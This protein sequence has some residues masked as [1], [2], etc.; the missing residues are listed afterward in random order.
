MKRDIDSPLFRCVSSLD[1]DC[2]LPKPSNLSESSG[3]NALFSQIAAISPITKSLHT[4]FPALSTVESQLI[5][6]PSHVSEFLNLLEDVYP[7]EYFSDTQGDSF[8]NSFYKAVSDFSDDGKQISE[9]EISEFQNLNNEKNLI[10]SWNEFFDEFRSDN[11]SF[12]QV[13]KVKKL[14]ESSK[15]LKNFSKFFGFND[16]FSMLHDVLI[17]VFSKIDYSVNA[18]DE[19]AKSVGFLEKSEIHEN[20]EFEVTVII[21]NVMVC[22]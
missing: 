13:K 9:K 1:I 14:T 16:P 15:K 11:S 5:D 17:T 7:F 21:T 20:E 12:Q 3:F 10:S 18:T 6:L 8:F 4:Y 22:F 2:P 19:I